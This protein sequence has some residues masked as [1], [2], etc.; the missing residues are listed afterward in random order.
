MKTPLI[1]T[2]LSSSI[3]RYVE[4]KRALGR[5][6]YTEYRVLERLNTF[7]ADIDVADFTW[8]EFEQWSQ[9]QSHLT[10]TTRRGRMQ[11]VRN[12]C[13]YRRRTEPR[14]F[15]PDINL[16]PAL[17]QAVQ[18]HIFSD[19][20]I[21]CLLEAASRLPAIP[22]SPLR[23]EV[24]RLAIV[25]LYCTGIR[26]GELVRLTLA[27]Y[28]PH[29]KTLLIRESKFH[30]SRYVPLAE[31]VIRELD[32]YL[33]TRR[34]RRLPMLVDS[35]LLWNRHGHGR[36]YTGQGLWQGLHALF[37]AADVRKADGTVPRV[38]DLRFT[39]AVQTLLRWYRSGIDVQAKLPLLSRY[40]GHVSIESTEYYLPLIPELALAASNQ[41]CRHYGALVQPL[42]NGGHAS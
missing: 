32:A 18:P 11:V 31:D 3:E 38:H 28:D 42:S 14:C 17:S 8:T 13:L 36:P 6:F 34:Q 33:T 20:Q 19:T 24:F 26:R 30:R 12:F 23:P 29:E 5:Q 4:L 22:T 1:K 21:M 2:C 35:P 40:M 9:A 27:D 41:F 7:M 15:V 16:F 37:Q 39:F 25:L 10:S